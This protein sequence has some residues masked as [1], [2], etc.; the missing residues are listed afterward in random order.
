MTEICVQ[1]NGELEEIKKSA[2][3]KGFE[4]KESYNNYDTYYSTVSEE[5]LK[6]VEYKKLLDNSVIVRNIVGDDVDIKNIVY[7]K[8]TLDDQGNVIE[9]IKTKLKI[10]DI[11][12]A[13]L[14]FKSLGLTCWC[15]FINQNNEYTKG[16]VVLNIQHVDELGTF[17]EIEE[18]D[19]IK[20]KSDEEKF[21]IL[22]GVINSLGFPIG[23]DYSCKK[24][25][26]YLKNN[27]K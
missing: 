14:I 8:K 15:D 17:I 13:K 4:F 9:E 3:E 11:Q 24:P 21:E 6:T 2:L 18:Y 20:D 25:Y 27:L 26:M 10:D 12:K 22:V 5:E 16:E 7:K 19:S 23:T 1:I